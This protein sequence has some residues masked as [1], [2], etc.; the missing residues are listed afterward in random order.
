VFADRAGVTG[1][2]ERC[3]C[4]C[5][6][7]VDI[8]HFFP[9]C[10]I[11]SP[12]GIPMSMDKKSRQDL[13]DELATALGC[14]EMDSHAGR[15]QRARQLAKHA[16]LSCP[17]DGA[18][19][20]TA[21]RQRQKT[22]EGW[23]PTHD[24]EH[25]NGA[26]A[27]AAVCYALPEPWRASVAFPMPYSLWPWSPSW[28]KPTPDDRVRELEKAGALIAAEIDRLLLVE[29]S[30]RAGTDRTTSGAIGQP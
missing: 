2:G 16:P 3:T 4:A 24:A 28:W 1:L 27:L 15:L 21:E 29:P 14:D 8:R 17:L 7:G 13:Y 23:T 22:E 30:V 19:R 18:A 9:C 10:F 5:H 20:I 11:A 12:E 25:T 26:L 6:R